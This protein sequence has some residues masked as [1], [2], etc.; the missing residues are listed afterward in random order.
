MQKKKKNSVCHF[1]CISQP[2]HPVRWQRGGGK[3]T[4]SWY[5]VCCVLQRGCLHAIRGSLHMA[6]ADCVAAPPCEAKLARTAA[7][8]C[9]AGAL[10]R[11]LAYASSCQSVNDTGAAAVR[12]SS[13]W[14][15]TGP[16]LRST[17]EG[18]E[19]YTRMI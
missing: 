9:K 11:L 10:A 18:E 6:S 2:A 19:S 17:C 15:T 12:R 13:H 5:H 14:M 8:N 1:D 16:L 4:G 7:V 3:G